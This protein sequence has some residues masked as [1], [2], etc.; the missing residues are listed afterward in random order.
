MLLKSAA[1][2]LSV[3]AKYPFCAS[4]NAPVRTRKPSERI[5][6]IPCSISTGVSGDAGAI[7][8]TTS[9]RRSIFG[10]AENKRAKLCAAAS[11]SQSAVCFSE[12]PLEQV[13][14][15]YADIDSRKVK[16]KPYGL[17]FTRFIAR[18]LGANPVWYVD[19]TMGRDWKVAK[20]LNDLRDRA[21][22]DGCLDKD[23]IKWVLPLC[24]QMGTWNGSMKEFW[25][26]RE[27][28]CARK[29]SFTYNDVAFLLCPEPEHSSLKTLLPPDAEKLRKRILDPS[30]SLETMIAHLAGI[31]KGDIALF[32]AR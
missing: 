12:S 21:I 9:P 19:M 10:F 24:E 31:S 25:W 13:Y 32:R 26:E 4:V 29:F 14:S 17:A 23:P 18:K 6:A 16:L 5:C 27:W 28:R 3:P 15:L 11:E 22:K 20:A 1:R 2:S 8:P 30:W 7:N